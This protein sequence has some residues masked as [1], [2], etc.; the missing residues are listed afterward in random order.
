M[1]PSD[2]PGP[3]E[4]SL[5]VGEGE[6]R[7]RK[8]I[9]GVQGG[10]LQPHTPKVALLFPTLDYLGMPVSSNSDSETGLRAC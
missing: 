8:L 6:K 2:G 7:N 5:R 9:Y 3:R 1:L 4:V 10:T